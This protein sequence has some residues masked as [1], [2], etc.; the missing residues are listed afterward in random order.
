MNK[1]LLSLFL[2]MLMVL[3]MLAGCSSKSGEDETVEA[4][5]DTE[6]SSRIS[7]TLT[8]WI[9]TSKDTTEE[10]ILATQDAINA[11]TQP[12]FNTAIELH[13]IPE[14]DYQEAIDERMAEITAKKEELELAEEAAREAAKALKEQGITET[15]PAEEEEAETEEE[16]TFVNELGITVVKYPEVEETQMDI[17]LVRG[18]ENYKRYIEE[19]AIQQLDSELSGTSKILKTYIYPTF[20]TL[21]NQKG[22]Y[23]IP[24][25]RPVG[26]YEYLLINKELVEAYDYDISN[27]T[28]LVKCED[29][30]A[31][32]GFQNLDGVIP[33]LDEYEAS[34]MTYWSED[35]S[36][37]LLGSQIT[38]VMDYNVKCMP[39]SVISTPVYTNTLL[40]MKRLDEAGYIGDGTLK[41]GE[42]FAVGIIKGDANTLAQYEDEYYSSIYTK[43]MA[44]ENDIFGNMFAVS[45]HSKSLAR[46]MEIISYLNTD[47]ELRTILQYGAEGVHWM[48]DPSNDETII[49]LSDD[50]KMDLYSTGNVYM[51]YP[52]YGMTMAD[53]DAGKQQNLD[54]MV[55]PYLTFDFSTI[56]EMEGADPAL[57]TKLAELSKNY[58]DQI[59]SMTADELKSAINQF[60]KEL[61][62]DEVMSAATD[63]TD[64]GKGPC[65]VYNAYYT[66][67]YPS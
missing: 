47:T 4:S 52:D 27:L 16:E 54:S 5:A 50:Y 55:S 59:D 62:S 14:K 19:E 60:K 29:F 20:L 13:A 35:G 15:E 12:K 43:P 34:N 18:Y 67:N 63:I 61:K 48:V 49:S 10:A 28:S 51:T 9:P 66:E 37:S 40:M 11:L 6:E 23:A 44:N 25:N 58:K 22:T 53:W 7:M 39:K 56:Y 3:S 46:S 21:A 17:F 31:D 2:A 36:W 38:Q 8:L 45:T 24:N 41:E 33:L 1:K 30:I 42:K 57:K 65:A 64:T 26:Q 32:I